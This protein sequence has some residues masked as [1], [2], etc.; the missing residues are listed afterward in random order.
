MGCGTQGRV[1]VVET[2]RRRYQAGE[3]IA[4]LVCDQEFDRG[5]QVHGTIVVHP[6]DGDQ[7]AH[8]VL[9]VDR[10]IP[11]GGYRACQNGTAAD[12]QAR[13]ARLDRER[14]AGQFQC[15]INRR[16]LQGV[17]NDQVGAKAGR[18]FPSGR[19]GIANRDPRS[20]RVGHRG[21]SHS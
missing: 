20:Q 1:E 7:P 11:A 3:W 10:D 6:G 12:I 8:Q 5:M 21:R 17:C 16:N 19:I 2:G 15:H 13:D 14:T 9:R 18:Y 4:V